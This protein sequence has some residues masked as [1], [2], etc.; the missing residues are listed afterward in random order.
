MCICLI[1]Y[2]ILLSF[3]STLFHCRSNWFFFYVQ[4]VEALFIKLNESWNLIE[5]IDLL[6]IFTCVVL[7]V[8]FLSTYLMVSNNE[9]KLSLCVVTA[10]NVSQWYKLFLI[11]MF[12]LFLIIII[13]EGFLLL[14]VIL[15]V[16]VFFFYLLYCLWFFALLFDILL[17]ILCLVSIMVVDDLSC[18]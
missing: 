3:L 1:V 16:M 18:L 14:F 11:S 12:L 2:V 13:S 10:Y 6:D 7:N 8:F 17:V 5:L 15:L 9:Y 4:V